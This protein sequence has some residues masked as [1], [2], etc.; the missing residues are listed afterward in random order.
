MDRRV[1]MAFPKVTNLAYRGFI[2]KFR[3]N[4]DEAYDWLRRSPQGK[5]D[6]R[7]TFEAFATAAALPGKVLPGNQRILTSGVS[8]PITGANVTNGATITL[9]IA[10]G[11][12]TA[13][14]VTGQAAP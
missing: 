12:L 14:V 4:M 2:T 7:D 3:Q 13:A 10:G 8:F 9:T 1:E 5:K 11:V 6:I